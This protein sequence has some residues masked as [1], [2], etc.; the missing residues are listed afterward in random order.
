MNGIEKRNS[1][2]HGSAGLRPAGRF[3]DDLP[4]G[5]FVVA[6]IAFLGVGVGLWARA[7]DHGLAYSAAFVLYALSQVG[8][9]TYFANLVTMKTAVLLEQSLVFAMLVWIV[10]KV[11]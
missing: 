9:L 1:F 11:T 8:F 4:K 3:L 10:L 2:L 7:N 5:L 6:H